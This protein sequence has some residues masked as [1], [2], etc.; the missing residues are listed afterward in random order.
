MTVP[1]QIATSLSH[2]GVVGTV[3][4][5]ASLRTGVRLR[6]GGPCDWLELRIDHFFPNVAGVLQAA[7]KMRLPRIITV[8]RLA[9][10]GA[11]R[12]LT[13]RDRRVLF[14]EFMELAALVDVELHSARS[15]SEVIAEARGAGVGVM[16]SHHD[17]H[18]T[19]PR[20]RL[21]E[22]ARR[23]RDAGADIFKVAALVEKERDLARLIEFLA[24][25]KGRMRLA[26]MG[27]G[28]YGR[29]SRLVLAQAGS[30]LNYAFLDAPNA[31]GQWPAALLKARIAEICKPA[32]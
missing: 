4:S 28:L 2:P 24:N 3:H 5:A 32:G 16:L 14:G 10:G 26:V 17:F 27:M 21:A 19:P 23:A 9:E 20:A 18:R 15:L 8:R 13:E 29:V 11:A 31:S 7:R 1:V 12:E 30:C 6:P 22:L 25:E